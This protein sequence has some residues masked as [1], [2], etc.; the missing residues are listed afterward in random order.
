M[1]Q[2]DG[3]NPSGYESGMGR[4]KEVLLIV[5][6]YFAVTALSFTRVLKVSAR[7][8]PRVMLRLLPDSLQDA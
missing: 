6:Y 2:G 4:R 3:G 7:P 1:R 8:L 5:L